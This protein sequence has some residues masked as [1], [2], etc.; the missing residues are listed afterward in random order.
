MPGYWTRIILWCFCV[1]VVAFDNVLFPNYQKWLVALLE[2][3]IP[4]NMSWIEYILPTILLIVGLN[5]FLSMCLLLRQLLY[6]KWSANI[7]NKISEVLTEYTQMQSMLFWTGRMPG[8]INRQID[9][10]VD[11]PFCIDLLWRSFCLAIML[12]LN[13]GLLFSVNI[14]V[15]IMFGV[16][17]IFRV[18][19]AWNMRN[20][21]KKATED[22]AETTSLLHGKLVD[23]LSNYSIVKSFA[24]R[25]RETKYLDAPRKNKIEKQLHVAFL[26]RVFWGVPGALW[27]LMFGATLFFCA[28]LYF[29]GELTIAEIVFTVGIYFSV[30]GSISQLINSIPDIIDKV[31]SAKK[32]YSELV[33]PIEISDK[34]NAKDLVVSKGKIEFKNVSFKYPSRKKWIIKD[35][36]FTIR[37]GERV[38]LVGSSGAGKT[39]LVN[40]LLR[41]Y[42]AT[43]GDIFIDGQNIKDVSQDSLHQNISFIPQEPTMFNRTIGENIAYGKENATDEEI[44]RAAKFASADK[45]IRTTENKYDSLVGDRGIKLSGGQRQRIAIARAFLKDAPILILDE[46]TSALDSETEVAIQ[47]SFDKL[48]AGHTTI[49]IAHRLSTLRNMDRIIVLDEGKIVESGTHAKLLR[50]KGVYYK[51]WKMQSGGFLQ[52]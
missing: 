3:G 38:G 42:E 39:T 35:L 27:D 30:M 31:G 16:A 4:Q 8:K 14:Y 32:A 49:A 1:L 20:P 26:N 29:R 7:Q 52:D 12:F 2:Q 47:S 51:L 11:L 6:V 50:Q 9:Y 19:F 40:L 10:I 33:V 13:A 5:L 21:L 28:M 46:A 15:A 44:H 45:F 17:F 37:A 24:G 23:S 25:K 18:V 41:F 22:K 36:S 34:E 48:S 43:H